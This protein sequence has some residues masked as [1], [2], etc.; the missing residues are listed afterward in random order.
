MKRGCYMPPTVSHTEAETKLCVHCM[1]WLLEGHSRDIHA[2]NYPILGLCALVCLLIANSHCSS[3]HT[4]HSDHCPLPVHPILLNSPTPP[5]FLNTSK[6]MEGRCTFEF[7]GYGALVI[8]W[9]IDN[10]EYSSVMT[11]T[12]TSCLSFIANTLA[13]RGSS[14]WE[15]TGKL[16]WLFLLIVWVQKQNIHHYVDTNKNQSDKL[17]VYLTSQESNQT[18][19]TFVPLHPPPTAPSPKSKQTSWAW[20]KWQHYC[21]LNV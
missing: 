21:S 5:V 10:C 3:M 11:F 17:H 9:Y 4:S 8:I 13:L 7:A 20:V 12:C 6:T 16:M 15:K 18:M 1:T 19:Y 14:F 2:N